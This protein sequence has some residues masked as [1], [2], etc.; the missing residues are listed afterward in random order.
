MNAADII[1]QLKNREPSILGIEEYRQYAIL[2]PL[3]EIENET[4]LL[5]EV[6][7]M[8]LRT[9]PG[10][11]CFPGGRVDRDDQNERSAAIRETSE[12]LGLCKTNICDV[13]PLDYMVFGFGRI[14]YPYIGRI[15]DMEQV[16]PNKDEV[17]EVFTV[18]LSYFL[19]TKPKI[20]K[21]NFKVT[22]E[23][24]FPYDLIVGGEDY[25]WQTSEIEEHFYTY[26]DRVIWGIT[27]KILTHFVSLLN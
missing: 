6:R 26:E 8:N 15:R 20:Y 23:K 13:I 22:P 1:T 4:H 14:I 7:S 17:E 11:I 3:V 25:D 24:N 18:P 19:E 16:V 21:V 27:A 5:F 10:D 12:E 9:Q 2:L